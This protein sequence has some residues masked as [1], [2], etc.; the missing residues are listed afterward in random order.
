MQLT[1]KDQEAGMQDPPVWAKY[2]IIVNKSEGRR[3]EMDR[4]ERFEFYKKAK[5]SFVIVH[6]GETALYGNII[7]TKGIIKPEDIEGPK[8]Y[9]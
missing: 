7:L 6:T 1:D 2:Q 4:I 8:K 9:H 5:E 3:V